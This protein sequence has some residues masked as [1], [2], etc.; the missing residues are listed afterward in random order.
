MRIV[1]SLVAALVVAAPAIGHADDREALQA[2]GEQLA[3]DGRYQDAIDAF[4][5]ADRIQPRASHA[6]LIALA[7]TRRESWPQAELFLSICH[8]RANAGDPLP[9]WVP[10]ADQMLKERIAA[11]NLAEVTIETKPATA[12][13]TVSSFAPDEVFEPR[14]VHLPLGTHVI[15]AKA[16]GYADAQ[17]TLEIKDKSPQHI[18]IDLLPVKATPT[19][20]NGPNGPAEPGMTTEPGPKRGTPFLIGGGAAILGGIA[21]HLWWGH[22]HDVLQQAH[23]NLDPTTWRDHS[24]RYDIAHY[25]TIGLYAVGVGLVATGVVLRMKSPESPAVAAVPLRGGGAMVSVEWSR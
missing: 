22:E 25:S 1:T 3:K 19:N 23:D 6:C 7:Y 13:V 20:P 4:K 11:A 16:E 9:D 15:F 2:K 12:R 17:S 24:T 8:Q 21:A 18:V 5:A 10:Q 14:T